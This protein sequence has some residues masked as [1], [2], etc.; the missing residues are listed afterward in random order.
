MTVNALGQISSLYDKRAGR[1]VFKKGAL[2]NLLYVLDDHPV[3]YDAWELEDHAQYKR[4]TVDTAATVTPIFDGTRAG[5]CVERK[6]MHSTIKQTVW[7][8][9]DDARI[10]FD[11]EIDW[12]DPHQ[13]LK[14]EFPFDVHAMSATY[15]VQFGHVTRPTHAN[16]SW[17]EAKFEIYAHKWVDVAEHGYGVA[18]LNDCKYG[19]S[20]QGSTLA[21]TLLKCP[22]DPYARADRGLHTFTYSLLPH[23][24]DFREAGVV[25][26]SWA[27]N[28]PLLC[29]PVSAHGGSLDETF[30]YVSCDADNIV[31]S[32]L[33]KAESDDGLIVRMYDAFDRKSRVSVSVP[34][35]FGKAYLC[36]LLE[37]EQSE[38]AIVD[39]HV[40]LPVSN[41]EIVT[42]KFA[43]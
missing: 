2:G 20:I 34:E 18:L 35:G 42:L 8:Y 26:E 41:F 31:I 11:N 13:I 9:S 21:L 16:T 30:S 36:D 5:L 17:D 32:A 29:T 24:G 39:G 7:F 4:W 28:Q 38:L 10:D 27:L 22:T 6:Y 3:K 14:A 33:K 12:Q 23:V 19:H 25:A 37:R 40:T 43:K 15:D 1:E